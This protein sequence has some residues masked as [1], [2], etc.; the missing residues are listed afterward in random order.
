MKLKVTT[1][2]KRPRKLNFKHGGGQ[3]FFRSLRS[4]TYPP[5]PT[6]KI[7]VVHQYFP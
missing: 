5:S 6:F 2:V 1:E 7:N 4:R 3:N